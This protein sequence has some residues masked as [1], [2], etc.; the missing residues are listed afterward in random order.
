VAKIGA[1]KG[2]SFASFRK[3]WAVAANRNWSL[4]PLGPRRRKST[5][6]EDA[7][8]MSEEHLDLLSL[9]TRDGVG[10]GLGDRTG[11][12]ASGFM[13]RARDFARRYV[14]AALGLERAGLAFYGHSC[15]LRGHAE[16]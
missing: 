10:L 8:Q 2:M 4:A 9:A 13:N 11:L 12:V 7:L 1:G 3:F 15:K 6:P 14:Q 5:E 16:Q